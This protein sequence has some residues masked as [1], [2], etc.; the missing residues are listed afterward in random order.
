MNM[1]EKVKVCFEITPKHD[2]FIF[3]VDDLEKFIKL[4]N[5]EIHINVKEK[6][7][8]AGELIFNKDWYDKYLLIEEHLPKFFEIFHINLVCMKIYLIDEN[9]NMKERKR[10]STCESII[11]V[12]MKEQIINLSKIMNASNSYFSDNLRFIEEIIDVYLDLEKNGAN[13]GIYSL[14]DIYSLIRKIH[15]YFKQNLK[16]GEEIDVNKIKEEAEEYFKEATNVYLHDI[17]DKPNIDSSY[18]TYLS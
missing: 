1:C 6:R 15:K 16:E 8:I 12:V 5:L 17:T 2:Y 10:N 18:V 4:P 13:M 7:R 9:G 11:E 3:N 14:I